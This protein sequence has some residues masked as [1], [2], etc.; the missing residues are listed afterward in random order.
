MTTSVFIVRADEDRLDHPVHFLNG[1]FD[2]KITARDTAGALLVIDTIRTGSGGPPLHYHHDVDEVFL[3]QEGQFRF[4][5]GDDLYE[6]D[7]G[8]V[9][10]GPRGIPHAFRNISEN[11][12]LM[13]MFQPAGSMEAF[14]SAQLFN[15]MSDEFRALS[16]AHGM[17][18][19]GPPLAA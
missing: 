11:G 8:D 15:P 1:R 4:R 12:R 17:E 5:I 7:E 16:R 6:L 3:V 19:V 10:F 9:L 13:V 18:V 2:T 14:F